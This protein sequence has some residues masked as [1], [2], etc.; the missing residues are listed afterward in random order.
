MKM[1]NKK[2]GLGL[3]LVAPLVANA[4]FDVTA[5]TGALTDI[6]AVG[7]AVFAVYVAIKVV[8]WARAAL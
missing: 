5:I 8:K 7:A 1:T 2:L 6:A 4:A 3:V